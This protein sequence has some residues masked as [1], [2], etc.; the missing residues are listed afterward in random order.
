MSERDIEITAGQVTV[1]AVLND[2][3][4]A[5]RI[6][7]AL[8]IEASASTWGDEIYFGIPVS[9][10]EEDA[11][12][13]VELGDLG[14]W[15]PSNAFCMFFGP[16]PMSRGDEIRPASPVTVIGRMH[17]DPTSLKRVGSGAPVLIERV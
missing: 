16:T 5:S 4:T 6:W 10:A 14:Y 9:A 3:D 13:V 1:S 15:P 8:P 11:H 2:S 12:E 17:G 7:D